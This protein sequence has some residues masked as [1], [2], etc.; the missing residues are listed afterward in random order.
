MSLHVVLRHTFRSDGRGRV[1]R[2]ACL[3]DA[4][5]IPGWKE[6]V[7][8]RFA[9]IPLR[10]KGTRWAVAHLTRDGR[11]VSCRVCYKFRADM[12]LCARFLL[13]QV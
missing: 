1:T 10:W 4:G 5:N 11:F 2:L 9:V 6:A 8:K 12:F 7:S 3:D 13:H